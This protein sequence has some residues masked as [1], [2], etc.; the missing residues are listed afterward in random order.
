MSIEDL[1]AKQFNSIVFFFGGIYL[2]LFGIKL[3]WDAAGDA[4]AVGLALISIGTVM[5][6]SD[7]FTADPDKNAEA[8]GSVE[9]GIIGL[10]AALT[11]FLIVVHHYQTQYRLD[12]PFLVVTFASALAG[13]VL[14]LKGIADFSN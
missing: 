3:Q 9:A 10:I 4:I 11:S 13:T 1:T 5:F 12:V 8:A 2:L 7:R 14:V 6:M